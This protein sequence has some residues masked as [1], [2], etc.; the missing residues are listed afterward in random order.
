VQGGGEAGD[1]VSR[2]RGIPDDTHAYFTRM[3][4]RQANPPSLFSDADRLNKAHICANNARSADADADTRPLRMLASPAARFISSLR[5]NKNQRERE[6]ER[7]VIRARNGAKKNM[8][9]RH[10]PRT[11][12]RPSLSRFHSRNARARPDKCVYRALNSVYTRGSRSDGK[13]DHRGRA[14]ER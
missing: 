14:R 6:R 4:I 9:L 10:W 1:G 8:R 12:A 3:L 7:R 5:V 13:N 11:H 2:R